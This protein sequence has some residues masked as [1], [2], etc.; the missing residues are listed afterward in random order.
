IGVIFMKI[1]LVR[2]A[3][4]KMKVN[5]Q[6][7]LVDPMLS[8]KGVMAPVGN[9]ANNY[10]NP[11]V[12]LP[13][14]IEEVISNIDAVLLTHSHRDHFDEKA[15]EVIPHDLPIFCQPEDVEKLKSLAFTKVLKVEKEVGWK[16]IQL[17]R[18]GGQHGTGELGKQMGP[19]SGFIL[20][21]E[22]E[23]TIY[24]AGDTI[25]CQD[26]ERAIEEHS[27]QLIILNGGEAQFLS[28]DP[29]TMGTWDIQ[30]V[31]E[32][33]P[34]S[35][36]VVTH[37]ESWNHCLL[38]RNDLQNYIKKNQLSNVIVPNDGEVFGC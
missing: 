16:G 31:S 3:T 24:I 15:L 11:L 29:I 2:H 4:I 10:Q 30:K 14:P 6:V 17:I 35:T 37:M 13:L 20:K 36:I 38:S 18:T 19:V 23:P 25:W 22:K 5:N 1:Q 32:M 26:V 28:G 7:F 27:P 21:A 33:S 9:A 12:D 8:A 34:T